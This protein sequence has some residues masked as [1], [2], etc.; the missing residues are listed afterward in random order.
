METVLL[1][2][3]V[4]A[5]RIA[6][7]R[8][9][10]Y[11]QPTIASRL[12]RSRRGLVTRL[13][14]AVV[15]LATPALIVASR[16]AHMVTHRRRPDLPVADAVR[17]A[18]HPARARTSADRRS[19]SARSIVA[20]RIA[21][22]NRV[23][24]D[25]PA[26]ASVQTLDT[27]ALLTPLP[28][29]SGSN[30]VPRVVRS[31]RTTISLGR[32]AVE[33]SL[34]IRRTAESVCA[35][36]VPSMPRPG[37]A[38]LSSIYDSVNAH[39]ARLL[40]ALTAAARQD[41]A[42]P[43]AVA[44]LVVVASVLSITPSVGVRGGTGAVEGPGQDARIAVLGAESSSVGNTTGGYTDGSGPGDPGGRAASANPM[45]AFRI[46][47]SEADAPTPP[48]PYGIDGTLL[49]PVAVDTSVPD[50]SDQLRTYRV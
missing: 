24:T 2:A 12:R 7:R 8:S 45:A 9:D 20:T 34:P 35:L 1:D 13:R 26:V 43:V 50:A 17:V 19:V 16:S 30:W 31:G 5:L 36:R 32:R 46:A 41:R 14:L 11:R 15:R 44:L 6:L 21:F 33:A 3:T 25:E 39:L 37:A 48:G 29:L 38:R 27:A 10:L 18:P 42:L 22:S 4:G 40:P 49:K 23:A 28:A 47:D